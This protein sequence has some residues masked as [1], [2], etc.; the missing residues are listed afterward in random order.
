MQT[1]LFWP[2]DSFCF[3]ETRC[4][5]AA[6]PNIT[7]NALWSVD[8]SNSQSSLLCLCTGSTSESWA[9]WVFSNIK[10][11]C[12]VLKKQTFLQYALTFL[13][14]TCHCKV[15]WGYHPAAWHSNRTD[16]PWNANLS[17]PKTFTLPFSAITLKKIFLIH[18]PA[19]TYFCII[20][21]MHVGA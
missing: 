11:F 6:A 12:S 18:V 7:M 16:C 3:H 17:S 1:T 8:V 19:C 9:W 21:Y 13:S 5:R 20:L 14:F 15:G 10:C 2:V 4:K